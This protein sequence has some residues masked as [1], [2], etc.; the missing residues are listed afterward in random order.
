MISRTRT[1]GRDIV[2]LSLA[3]TSG[4]AAAAMAFPPQCG[5][6]TLGAASGLAS[7]VAAAIIYALSGA[8]RGRPAGI[9]ASVWPFLLL[10][11]LTGIFCYCTSLLSMDFLPS[12]FGKAYTGRALL[13]LTALADSIDWPHEHSAALVKALL[14]GSRQ[15]LDPE[16]VSDFRTAGASHILALSGLHLG[17]IYGL[18]SVLL[19]PLGRS[20]PA[21]A[22]RAV[23]VISAAAFYSRMTGSGPS[24]ERAAIFITLRELSRISPGRRAGPLRIFGA[25]LVLQLAMRPALITSPGFQLS[26]LAM[27]GILVVHPRLRSL[28]PEGGRFN[29]LYRLWNAFSLSVSCQALTAPAVWLHFG[30]IPKYFI[31]TNIVALPLT[32]AVII[33]A[34]VCLILSALGL[35]PGIAKSLTDAL[36][37]ALLYSLK[38]I[39]S[40]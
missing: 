2:P 15:A 14:T 29:P 21:V 25:S 22:A 26:Y 36:G 39:A 30:S 35:E 37:Q 20:R 23:L 40:I 18:L 24:V 19:L 31:I 38:A 16:V 9:R 28:Y 17:V 12:G 7:A 27:L 1:P 34:V 13:R 5:A 3:F 10:F 8:V 11:G 32:E 6:Q 4:A 33:G